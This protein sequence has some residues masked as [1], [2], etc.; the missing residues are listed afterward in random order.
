[1]L[2]TTRN[3]ERKGKNMLLNKLV[4]GKRSS[5]YSTACTRTRMRPMLLIVLTALPLTTTRTGRSWLARLSKRVIGWA[6]SDRSYHDER[7]SMNLSWTVIETI[8][9]DR[10]NT[11]LQMGWRPVWNAHYERHIKE[12]TIQGRHLNK[13]I[14]LYWDATDGGNRDEAYAE[15]WD[16]EEALYDGKRI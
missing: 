3:P 14:K 11:H 15:W 12:Y 1:M 4:S 9:D 6:G 5:V 13:E 16:M 2:L 8:T 10:T 7:G